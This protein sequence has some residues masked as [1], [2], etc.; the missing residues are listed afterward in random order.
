[1]PNLPISQL[2]E[3]TAITSNA[4]YAVAQNG[5]TYK[6]KAGFASSGNLHGAFHSE[7]N[8]I[9]TSTTAAYSLSAETVDFASGVSVVDGCKFTV[10][11]GG[12]FNF[13]FS[14][15]FQKT[16]GGSIEFVS[17]WLSKNGTNVPWTNTDVSMANNN[18]YVISAWNF[19]EEMN[20]G[21]YLELKWRTTTL[22][23]ICSFIGE[24]SNPTRPG[25]P[26]VII[27][28]TQI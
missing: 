4:E 14:A 5:T 10:S 13:Q 2:P 20:A 1:M 24:Q 15:V 25:T 27:T 22:D 28:I 23:M 9:A 21:D 17:I 3:L 26:S 7:V 12:T 11:S 6:V 18:E 8:Q 19:V 16:Q